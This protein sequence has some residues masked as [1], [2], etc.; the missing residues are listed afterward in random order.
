MLGISHIQRVLMKKNIQNEKKIF[1]IEL[2]GL[3][4]SLNELHARRV[5]YL[6]YR[7]ITD[8]I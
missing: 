3:R 6:C 7:V 8:I 2:I 1:F 4:K 5:L